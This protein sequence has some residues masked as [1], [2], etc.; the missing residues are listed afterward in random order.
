MAD[1]NN[2][3]NFFERGLV[4]FMATL[5]YAFED[6]YLLT[7]TVRRDGSSVLSP[8]NQYFTYPA[9]GAGLEYHERRLHE[10]LGWLNNLKLRGGWGITSNQGVA[11]YSTLGLLSTSTYN[12]GQATPGQATTYL[13]TSLANTHLHWEQ[14]AQTNIGLDFG[15]FQNRISGT[16]DVYQQKY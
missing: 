4:S 1:P 13:V 9:L 16:I 7:A 11:P 5:N 3:G 6:K 14:T 12:F 2:P 10:G 8:G 15:L